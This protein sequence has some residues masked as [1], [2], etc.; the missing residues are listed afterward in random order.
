MKNAI[1]LAAWVRSNYPYASRPL[2]HLKLQKLSF[3]C[4]GAA[5]AFDCETDVGSDIQFQAWAHGP[6]NRDIYS[7]YR[8]FG[9]SA[10]GEYSGPDITYSTEAESHMRDV[11]IV[12][13]P[14]SAWA[15]RQES[16]L[17]EPWKLYAD[18]PKSNIPQD[19]LR[20]HFKRKFNTGP[21]RY[22]EYLA[23]VSNFALDGIPVYPHESLR[24]LAK[25]VENVFR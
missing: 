13:G 1:A 17:E 4:Y 18:T 10:I 20:R 5:L 3:Y 19:R 15:L 8:E 25:S 12:Y 16:H 7:E 22:P 6:V 24:S 11:L 23:N 9:G 2:T 21:V 14:L